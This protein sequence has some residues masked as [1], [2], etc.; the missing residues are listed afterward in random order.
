[1]Q[2]SPKVGTTNGTIEGINEKGFQ[3]N[4]AETLSVYGSPGR[5][6]TADP[7][8]NSPLRT[9]TTFREIR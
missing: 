6:R 3:L 2:Y 4:L 7:V 9:T 1:M 5:A 8:I